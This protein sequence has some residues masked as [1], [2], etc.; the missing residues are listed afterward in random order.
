M[1]QIQRQQKEFCKKNIYKNIQYLPSI[2]N[3]KKQKTLPLYLKK[4]R[5]LK[6]KF[7]TKFEL[8]TA[9]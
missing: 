9:F 5:V 8:R 3:K 2:K 7:D 4:M 6:K 1:F